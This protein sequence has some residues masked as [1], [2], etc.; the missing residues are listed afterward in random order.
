MSAD[1]DAATVTYAIARRENPAPVA[2]RLA[3]SVLALQ[4]VPEPHAS[5]LAAWARRQVEGFA[6]EPDESAGL[7][8]AG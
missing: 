3:R 4:G 2:E 5:M 7:A 6:C 1:L 8:E